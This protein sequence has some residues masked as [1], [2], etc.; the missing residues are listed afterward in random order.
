MKE[1]CTQYCPLECDSMIFQV[2]QSLANYP[3]IQHATNDLMYNTIIQSKFPNKNLTYDL[4][5][6]SVLSLNVYYSDL[7]YMEYSQR[8]KTTLLDL[9]SNIGGIVGVFIGASFLSILE[10]AEVLIEVLSIFF[11]RNKVFNI[12][13]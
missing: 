3:S 13:K 9:V 5:K 10:I 7:S 1:M 2:T 4:I 11:T 8:A 12:A 6:Q